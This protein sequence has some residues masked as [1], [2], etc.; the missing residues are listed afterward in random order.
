MKKWTEKK[1]QLEK[2][3]A[4]TN[5]PKLMEGDY[6]GLIKTLKKLIS[7]ANSVVSQLAIKACGCIAKGLRKDFGD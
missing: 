2:L 4:D 6:S 5:T 3:I 7:D 1:E